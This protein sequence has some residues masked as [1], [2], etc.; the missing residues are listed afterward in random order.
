MEARPKE[1]T[2]LSP[3][4]TPGGGEGGTGSPAFRRARQSP[5]KRAGQSDR[6]DPWAYD[7]LLGRPAALGTGEARMA[8]RVG[9]G[10]SV[11]VGDFV[12]VPGCVNRRSF[13]ANPWRCRS[14]V[15]PTIRRL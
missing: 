14:S 1:R 9:R 11:T 10:R 13:S 6:A 3:S 7:Q 2:L 5:D 15:S 8:G 4:P 12:R